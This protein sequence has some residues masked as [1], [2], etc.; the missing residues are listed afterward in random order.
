MKNVLAVL[1]NG[2]LEFEYDRTRPLSEQ[3]QTYLA[4]MDS[5]MNSG[6]TLAGKA[7]NNPDPLQR[8]QY[9]ADHLARAVNADNEPIIAA[10]CAYLAHRMPELKQIKIA[11]RGARMSIELVFDQSLENQVEVQFQ[12]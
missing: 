4:K 5:A 1:V 7:I 3:H 9:V 6:V 2:K 10:T 12:M 8:A 11:D